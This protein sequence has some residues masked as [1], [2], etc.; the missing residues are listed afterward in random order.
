MINDEKI[1]FRPGNFQLKDIRA[2]KILGDCVSLEGVPST[3]RI[4]KRH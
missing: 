4:L 1:T 2:K 3:K